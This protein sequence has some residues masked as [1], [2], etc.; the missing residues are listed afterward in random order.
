MKATTRYDDFETITKQTVEGIE[1]LKEEVVELKA[2]ID[3]IN[4]LLKTK[5][6]FTAKNKSDI[7]GLR[8]KHKKS[9]SE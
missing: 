5:K 7:D 6:T 9:W 2:Q 1:Y 3:K 8:G 4:T